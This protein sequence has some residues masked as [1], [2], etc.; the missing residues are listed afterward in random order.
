MAMQR[1]REVYLP[2][3]RNPGGL[4]K[5][6]RLRLVLG[7]ESPDGEKTYVSAAFPSACGKTNLAML[8]PPEKYEKAGW[9]T[10]IIGDDIAWLWPHEDGTLHAINPETGYFGVA[11]GTSY[12]TNPIAMDSMKENNWSH[13]R[14]LIMKSLMKPGILKPVNRLII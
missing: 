11:P 13:L 9:K 12:D 8:V 2:L 6:I 7:L 5:R 14:F 3:P 4:V 1:G 10:T